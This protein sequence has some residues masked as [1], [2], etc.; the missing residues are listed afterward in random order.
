MG[1]LREISLAYNKA[2][3]DVKKYADSVRKL[4]SEQKLQFLIEQQSVNGSEGLTIAQT[5]E[6]LATQGVSAAVSQ[7]T[8]EKIN[9]IATTKETIT[10]LEAEIATR[11]KSVLIL[12]EESS[13]LREQNLVEKENQLA[14]EK[15]RL[16][17]LE[18]DIKGTALKS[19]ISTGTMWAMAAFSTAASV[20]GNYSQSQEAENIGEALA[21]GIGGAFTSALSGALIGSMVPIPGGT[22]IGAA[23]GGV[24]PLISSLVGWKSA[25]TKRIQENITAL[26]EEASSYRKQ[27]GEVS[28]IVKRYQ[29]LSK[30]KNLSVEDQVEF[31]DLHE[32]LAGILATEGLSLEAVG[33]SLDTITGKY[34]LDTE[35]V[36]RLIAEL[37]KLADAREAAAAA[38]EL[39]LS[40]ERAKG[41]VHAPENRISAFGASGGSITNPNI[42]I[43][44]V[45]LTEE[46][47]TQ[48]NNVLK[49]VDDGIAKNI[50]TNASQEY[51]DDFIQNL[52]TLGNDKVAIDAALDSFSTDFQGFY[53]TINNDKALQDQ[54]SAFQELRNEFKA[55]GEGSAELASSYYAVDKA[56][57]DATEG[58]TRAVDVFGSLSEMYSKPSSP[59]TSGFSKNIDELTTATVAWRNAQSDTEKDFEKSNIESILESWRES[60]E[61]IPDAKLRSDAFKEYDAY[62]K[63][64]TKTLEGFS[65]ITDIT[66]MT[67]GWRNAQSETEKEF[68]KS[69]IEENLAQWRAEI[70]AI[71]NADLRAE[72]FEK[73]TAAAEGVAKIFEEFTV[74]GLIDGFKVIGTAFEEISENG[75]AAASTMES[76][77]DKV[78]ATE[79]QL[80]ALQA[81]F[82]AGDMDAVET[83]LRD[84][85]EAYLQTSICTEELTESQRQQ[86]IID[87]ESMGVKNAALAVEQQLAKTK[88]EAVGICEGLTTA[89]TAEA[90]GWLQVYYGAKQALVIMDLIAQKEKLIKGGH[91]SGASDALKTIND[92]IRE[93]INGDP[94][95]IELEIDFPTLGAS[96]GGSKSSGEDPV[97][98]AFEERKRQRQHLLATDIID[99]QQYL[100]ELEADYKKTF[101][102]IPKYL[103]EFSENEEEV[104]EGRRDIFKKHINDYDDLAEDHK[105]NINAQVGYYKG[106]L[107]DIEN[108]MRAHIAK[109]L[110]LN[111]D[112]YEE[113]EDMRRD[114]IDKIRQLLIDDAK[115]QYDRERDQRERDFEAAQKAREKAHEAE[116][117]YL[118]K[119]LDLIDQQLDGYR[120]IVEARKLAIDR[121]GDEKTYNDQVEESE[122]AIAKLRAQITALSGD[123]SA[124]A[125]AMRLELEVE[126]EDEL[127]KLADLAYDRKATLEKQALDDDLSRHEAN[128]DAEKKALDDHISHTKKKFDEQQEY[129][130][131]SHQNMLDNM[132]L[133]HN[134]FV[135][136]LENGTDAYVMSLAS[137]FG[138][139]IQQAQSAAQ[140]V[141]SSFQQ[142]FASVRDL[143]THLVGQGFDLPKYGIDNKLGRETISSLQRYL[144]S[145]GSQLQIDGILGPLT[146]AEMRKYGISFPTYHKGGIVGEGISKSELKKNQEAFGLKSDEV[147]ARMQIGEPVIPVDK[148][149]SSPQSNIVPLLG[150][151]AILTPREKLLF[152]SNAPDILNNSVAPS[153]FRQMLDVISN[154]VDSLMRGASVALA[155][156]GGGGTGLTLQM[157]NNLY[158]VESATVEKITDSIIAKAESRMFRTMNKLTQ[159]GRGFSPSQK[160]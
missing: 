95:P 21:S 58:Q 116:I 108:E 60:I 155:G 67:K 59:S 137:R 126:L 99:Q 83:T 39:E 57:S 71:S 89:L 45:G 115:D 127:K 119:Q 90:E 13:A 27:A 8:A 36:Q 110:S 152:G 157:T 91:F 66:A 144:N 51:V 61:A 112:Y 98:K 100:D 103:E 22:L 102:G 69:R 17:I 135:T 121:A 18:K 37:Y 148:S 75:A 49:T 35:A 10:L 111:S 142:A 63:R 154:K 25:E 81:A 44:E 128:L 96:S 64:T 104:L 15:S 46:L 6:A 145:L 151:D 125:N 73:Y 29:E 80:L 33:I 5:K 97:T 118:E 131:Q 101:G 129:L 147:M 43:D 16:E 141:V 56:L 34:D 68:E 28:S 54:I 120:A 72:E 123:D 20:L 114:Y 38:D 52:R 24:I 3:Q 82:K 149:V 12:D 160:Y 105:G 106:A 93:A 30:S 84:I 134:N 130:D 31:N 117:E 122:Q 113:L 32:Q 124:K 53:D 23:V 158:G 94:E 47:Q 11:R 40:R 143:Q 2:D 150:N 133:S 139:L 153:P 14:N 26:E 136:M 74:S 146:E 86:I 87:L 79:E 109:G 42:E 92:K 78:G 70:E 62:A 85:A 76:L 9:A 41:F 88:I 19:G 48:V 50:A 156:A 138:I 107:H 7:E 132:E 159:T 1:S 77:K 4:G 65:I 140:Q 55:T